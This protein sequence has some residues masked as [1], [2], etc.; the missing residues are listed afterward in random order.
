MV[1]AM[2]T[3]GSATRPKSRRKHSKRASEAMQDHEIIEHD[4]CREPLDCT[5][6]EMPQ[7]RPYMSGHIGSYQ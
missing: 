6:L 1:S 3:S 2:S 4:G 5:A 7:I